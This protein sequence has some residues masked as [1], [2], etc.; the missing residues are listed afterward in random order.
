[1]PDYPHD[2]WHSIE[3]MRGLVLLVDTSHGEVL[4]RIA[5]NI[6]KHYGVRRDRT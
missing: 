6:Y 4:Q 1:M 3:L 5:S 2:A